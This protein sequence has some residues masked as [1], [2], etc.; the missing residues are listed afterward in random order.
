MDLGPIRVLWRQP[1]TMALWG[2]PYRM[3][4][5]IGQSPGDL[6][7]ARN[8]CGWVWLGSP[9]WYGSYSSGEIQKVVSFLS[10]HADMIPDNPGEWT[11]IED[12]MRVQAH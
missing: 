3:R 5:D 9:G 12:G 6:Y 8:T 2:I 4:H 1:D 10:Y 11:E 7:E